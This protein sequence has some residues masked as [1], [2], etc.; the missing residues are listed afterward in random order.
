[1][2]VR[3]CVCAYV[4]LHAYMYVCEGMCLISVWGTQYA[5]G[6]LAQA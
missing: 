2:C 5:Y 3:V 4:G 6:K 1:M